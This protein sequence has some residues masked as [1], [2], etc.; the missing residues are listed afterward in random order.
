MPRRKEG[1]CVQ[2]KW[3][4]Q[5]KE[6]SSAALS[7]EVVDGL[8]GLGSLAMGAVVFGG[9]GVGCA[10]AETLLSTLWLFL[11]LQLPVATPSPDAR[12]LYDDLL[13]NY[14]R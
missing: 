5:K 10:L 2:W 6:R 4:W 3:K 13:S 12:R 9:G 11:L 1:L 14:N 7:P 8:R